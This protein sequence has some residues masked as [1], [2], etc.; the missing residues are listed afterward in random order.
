MFD[1]AA[2]AATALRLL[3]QFGAAVTVTRSTRTATSDEDD[4]TAVTTTLSATLVSVPASGGTVEAFD[5]RVRDL[6]VR[7][8][9]R[10]FVS[11]PT[12]GASGTPVMEGDVVP[13]DGE[14]YRVNGVTNVKPD[15]ATLLVQKFGA[16]QV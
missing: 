11:T 12:G 14:S 8:K 6:Y 7:G 5:D 9:M 1:Y 13:W 3:G 2:T 10:F 16:S 4:A 15:G